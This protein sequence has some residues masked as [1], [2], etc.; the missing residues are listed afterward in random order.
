MNIFSFLSFNSDLCHPGLP[1]KELQSLS[2]TSLVAGKIVPPASPQSLEEQPAAGPDSRAKGH[3]LLTLGGS[4]RGFAGNSNICSGQT[5]LHYYLHFSCKNLTE[6]RHSGERTHRLQAA[7]W[8]G[9]HWPL[10]A[11]HWTSK[12]LA[13]RHSRSSTCHPS[14]WAITLT[15]KACP[16]IPLCIRGRAWARGLQWA[17]EEETS[18]ITTTPCTIY[19]APMLAWQ[20]IGIW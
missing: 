5:G 10:D 2:L 20:Q 11:S 17:E 9:Q 3:G 8:Q 15:L 16:S 7:T 12:Q 18:D 1:A 6:T 4:S 14:N 19:E 13:I